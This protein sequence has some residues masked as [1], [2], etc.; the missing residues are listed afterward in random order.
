[1]KGFWEPANLSA[2]LKRPISCS[3][4]FDCLLRTQQNVNTKQEE[5]EDNGDYFLVI[6]HSSTQFINKLSISKYKLSSLKNKNELKGKKYSTPWVNAKTLE[7]W[8]STS[9]NRL[10]KKENL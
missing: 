10:I 6:T 5:T 3:L 2:T 7:I 8:F 9:S 1:M 4:I